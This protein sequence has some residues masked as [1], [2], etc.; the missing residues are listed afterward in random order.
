MMEQSGIA[1]AEHV[2]TWIGDWPR[3]GSG[4]RT[5]KWSRWWYTAACLTTWPAI[6]DP[7]GWWL[8]AL[9]TANT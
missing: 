3:G 1:I 7:C 8:S 5:S 2:P 9:A 6:T 4:I